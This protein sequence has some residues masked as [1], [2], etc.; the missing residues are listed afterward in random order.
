M[1]NFFPELLFLAPFSAL[2][3]RLASA[4]VFGYLSLQHF[5]GTGLARVF[6]ALEGVCAMLFFLGLYTQLAAILG[7]I[8][9]GLHVVRKEYTLPL[10]TLLLLLILCLS[11]L[12]TGAGPFTVTLGTLVLP[13][14]FDLPL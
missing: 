3:I 1:L 12:V 10:S 14:S 4:V 7:F 11:L 6:G 2:F 5:K 13:L 9:A 8:V